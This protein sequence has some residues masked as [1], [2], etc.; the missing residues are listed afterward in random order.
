MIEID[1]LQY[2]KLKDPLHPK[3]LASTIEDSALEI[4]NYDIQYKHPLLDSDNVNDSIKVRILYNELISVKKN[5]ASLECLVRD[6]RADINTL[7]TN[8]EIL[9]NEI[10]SIKQALYFG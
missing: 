8:N 9:N 5:I 3:T 1:Q 6:L 10:T 4:N 7:R 2:Y